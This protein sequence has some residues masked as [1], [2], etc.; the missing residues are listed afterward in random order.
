MLRLPILA[1]FLRTIPEGI[2]LVS[3]VYMILNKPLEKKICI[4]GGLLGI[5]TY[6]IRMFPIHFG[7]HLILIL[8]IVI[9]LLNKINH[10]DF[11]KAVTASIVSFILIVICESI[12]IIFY[13]NILGISTEKILNQSLSSILLGMPSLLLLICIGVTIKSLRRYKQGRVY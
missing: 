2:I 1:L 5:A 10:I 13:V 6:V 12:T 7:V 9:F 4:A 8:I 3:V 11:Y